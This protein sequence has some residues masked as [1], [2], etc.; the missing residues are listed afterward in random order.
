MNGIA[1]LSPIYGGFTPAADYS[2]SA[3]YLV[4]LA[5]AGVITILTS[6]TA[7]HPFGVILEGTTT[8]GKCTVAAC[9]GQ[10]QVV[11]GK[12]AASLGGTVIAGTNLIIT[13]AG[14]FDYDPGS[15]A[16]VQCAQAMEAGAAGE[17][18]AMVLFKPI[19]LS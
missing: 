5:A 15:G 12:L 2:A 14:T 7:S 6:A 17:L 10:G 13:S 3:G 11:Y 19:T 4:T 18:I 9:A 8:A 1:K 16:R